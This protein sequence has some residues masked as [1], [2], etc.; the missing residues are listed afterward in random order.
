MRKVA[1]RIAAYVLIV[2][3][4]VAV[5]VPVIPGIPLIAAGVAMLGRDHALVR[6][7]WVWLCNRG[8]VNDER[9]KNEMPTIRS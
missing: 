8:I 4:I 1:R 5:P 9:T 6:S 7:G 2:A 3:G